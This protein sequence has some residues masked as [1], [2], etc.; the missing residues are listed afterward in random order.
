MTP[1]LLLTRFNWPH[2]VWETRSK[3]DYAA[4]LEERLELLQKYTIPSVR[5]NQRKPDMWAI[6]AQAHT[7]EFDARLEEALTRANCPCVVLHYASKQIDGTVS[8]YLRSGALGHV[9][10]LCTVRLDSDD[11][12]SSDFFIRLRSFL[13]KEDDGTSDTGISFPGGSTL[14][15]RTMT[16]FYFSYPDN[17]FIGLIETPAGQSTVKTV[18]MRMHTDLLQ[19]VT[20]ARYLRSNRPMWC[21]IVHDSNLANQS[22]LQG[23]TLPLADQVGLLRRF[24]LPTVPESASS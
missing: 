18:F 10:R 6:L 1:I 21:S 22:L 8:D 20:K 2:P 23:T 7:P 3:A 17:P 19:N 16:F 9:E 24:G 5:N 13:D 15:A 11:V 14:N 12:I 4:W